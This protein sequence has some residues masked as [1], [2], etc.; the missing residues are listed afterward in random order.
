MTTIITRAGKGSALTWVE[1]DANITNLNTYKI[2]NVADDTTP[3]LGGNL[4][5]KS[6][7][8]SSS[9]GSVSIPDTVALNN[10]KF[11]TTN[12]TAPASVG[13]LVYNND[14]G[15][16]ELLCKA[17]NVN[18]QIGQE[19]LVRIHNSTGSTLTDGQVVYLSGANGAFP[20]VA[21]ASASS[22][23]TSSK[24]VGMVTETIAN[25]AEGFVTIHGL[26]NGLN[27]AAY[28]SG[29]KIWLSTT[30]GQY[31]TTRPDAPNHAVFIGWV[32]KANAGNGSILISIQN[33]Q[34]LDE[35]H[36]VYI[37]SISN[38]QLLKYNS[39]NTRWENWTPDY[40]TSSAIGTTVQAYDADLTSWAAITPSAKQ[41]TLVSGTNIKTIN[42]SSIL[43]SGDLTVSG[44]G[45][46]GETF[47]PFLLMGC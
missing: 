44:S 21:L 38:N 13:Q 9:T 10:I 34:E 6:Y 2:E 18:L 27:T 4:D 32:V 31:T 39:T 17:G 25:G 1:G 11:D 5:T 42:G 24:T 28:N 40:L 22:E 33:G 30:A 35:L 47:N 23:A 7:T 12:I 16:L 14:T 46:A 37:S 26:V 36:D 29:D 20:T 41:D 8:I 15:T 3:E 45:G 19:H 43:G